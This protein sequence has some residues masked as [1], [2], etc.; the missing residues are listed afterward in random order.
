MC[1]TTFDR[2]AN[3]AGLTAVRRRETIIPVRSLLSKLTANGRLAFAGCLAARRKR[4]GQ[5]QLTGLI[6]YDHHQSRVVVAALFSQPS[7]CAL[8][9]RKCRRCIRQVCASGIIL[10]LFACV[11]CKE[12]SRHST[13]A[14]YVEA[15]RTPINLEA[16]HD[17]KAA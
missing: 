4:R 2:R 16:D 3:D 9:T 8:S 11:Y 14:H 7:D 1:R 6:L 15:Q 17:S 12:I 5:N 10:D 13:F